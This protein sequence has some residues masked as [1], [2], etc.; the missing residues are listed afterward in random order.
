MNTD[1]STI[2]SDVIL[3][4][5]TPN[6]LIPLSDTDGESVNYHGL[7]KECSGKGKCTYSN[8]DVFEGFFIKGNRIMGR[9]IYKNGDVLNGNWASNSVLNGRYIFA[10]GDL[11]SGHFKDNLPHGN[12]LFEF[13][14]SGIFRGDWVK[15]KRDGKGEYMDING[16]TSFWCGN[17]NSLL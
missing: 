6:F 9:Y 8:G 15:G 3:P 16:R 12:G 5:R 2:D 13:N 11:Y 4:K 14:G 17:H 10:N 7:N 1:N